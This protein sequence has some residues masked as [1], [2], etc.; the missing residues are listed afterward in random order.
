[1]RIAIVGGGISGL[2]AAYRLHAEHEITLYEANNYVGG[3]THTVQVPTAAGPLPIDTG[4]IVYNDRTYPE[5]CRLLAELGVAGVPTEMSFSVHDPQRNFEYNGHSLNGLFAQRRNLW[6]PR[7]YRFLTEILRFN[8]TAA[9]LSHVVTDRTTVAEFLA[10]QRFSVDL[11]R[12][13]LYPMGSAIWSCPTGEFERFPIRFV[14]EFYHHH[15]LLDLHNRPQWYVIAGGSQT[16]VRAMTAAFRDRIRLADP[17]R[18]IRRTSQGVEIDSARGGTASFDHVI[19]ACHSDQTLRILGQEATALERT[20]LGAFPYVPNVA[21]LHCDT[22]WLPR[23]RRAWASWNYLVHGDP[24]TPASVTYN[25]N[26][27]Q[28]LQASKTY[29]VTLNPRTPID[30]D[31]VL[32]TFEYHHPVFTAERS[33]MQARCAE[34]QASSPHTSFCGAYWG[35]GFHEDGVVSA[36]AVVRRLAGQP[37]LQISLAE[38]AVGAAPSLNGESLTEV[39]S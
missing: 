19:F 25:M 31:K 34:L 39:A 1:M 26:I 3:H 4:F 27:L 2:V 37:R 20:V 8:R 24:R 18:S 38:L 11:A 12:D 29:C 14:A 32:A 16:Y 13:Y 36:L 22:S 35:N 23:S 30:P 5:F 6:R 28:R 21:V 33:A 15:G 9:K 7:F 10:E 17:V